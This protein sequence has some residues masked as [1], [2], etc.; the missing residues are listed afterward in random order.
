MPESLSSTVEERADDVQPRFYT[1]CSTQIGTIFLCAEE[2]ALVG[3]W[4]EGQKYFPDE[5]HLGTLISADEHTVLSQAVK[6]LEEYFQGQR[7]VFEVP[8][9]PEGTD[10]QLA[11]WNLVSDIRY[12][13]TNTYGAISR[14]VGPG[15]PAQAVGQAV[16]RNPCIIFIPCH[17]VLGAGG[18]MT[19]YAG[20][21]SAK[22]WLLELERSR[23]LAGE[24]LF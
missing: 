21:L 17:R 6:E 10:F 15:A 24:R 16:G 13:Y 12:G 7:I 5:N 11:V 2:D 9:R 14:I 18:K 8:L 4:L 3:A 1:T 19:G 23:K 20:G 22:Q